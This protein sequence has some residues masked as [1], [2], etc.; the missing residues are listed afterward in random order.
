MCGVECCTDLEG[1]KASGSEKGIP[2]QSFSQ[3]KERERV[4]IS[5]TFSLIAIKL[6]SV[7]F[8]AQSCKHYSSSCIIYFYHMVMLIIS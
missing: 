4:W 7:P 1:S 8:P 6:L 3:A 2:L 5:C